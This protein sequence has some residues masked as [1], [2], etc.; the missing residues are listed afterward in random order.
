MKTPSALGFA[1]A[2]LL[3]GAAQ[4]QL[5]GLGLPSIGL[6]PLPSTPMPPPPVRTQ[7]VVKLPKAKPSPVSPQPL[8]GT[9]MAA[10]GLATIPTAMPG[11]IPGTLDAVTA[12]AGLDAVPVVGADGATDL[13]LRAGSRL[14][15]TTTGI[16]GAVEDLASAAG[17]Y[18]RQARDLLQRHGEAVEADD[19]GQP[20]VR[21]EI[22]GLGVAPAAL[23]HARAAGFKVRARETIAGLGLETVI[24][25]APRGM[26]APEAIRRLRALDPTGRY[27]FNHIYFESGSVRG[28]PPGPSVAAAAS[29]RGL[30]IGLVDGTAEATQPTLARV[31]LVQ[32]AFA[33]GGSRVTAHATAVASLLAGTGGGFRGAAPGAALY[34]ADV[35]GTTA[36]GG[37]A[38]SIVRAFGWLA[39]QRAPVI[40]VSLV[41]PPNTLLAAGVATLVGKGY[42]VVAAV[43]NDGPAAPPLYP[44]AYPGVVAVTAVDARRQVLPEAGRG[45]YVGFAAPGADMAAAGLDGRLIGVR[46]A[47]F[48]APLAAGRLARLLPAPDPEGAQQAIAALGREAVDLGAAGRDPVYG[49]GLVAFELAVRPATLAARPAAEDR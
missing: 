2:I 44:A 48:A 46:G 9:A 24:L 12:D 28:A 29:G 7:P 8:A 37:S 5:G 34:V 32:R 45:P 6:P 40:N 31:P 38:L 10:P 1:A 36:A 43:G 13:V 14:K 27:D 16:A 39:Q 17:S 20:I 21:G 19:K 47:S 18:R 33:P 49:R 41:G 42:V 23:A 15:D 35:Y 30:R 11:A 22:A 4:A 3:A 26:A 25:T